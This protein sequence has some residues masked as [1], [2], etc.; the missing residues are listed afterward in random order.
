MKLLEEKIRNKSF[1][2]LLGNDFVDL[3]LKGK[4]T[5]VKNNQVGLHQSNKLLNSKGNHQR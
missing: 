3:T 1:D 2:I 4:A 5:E